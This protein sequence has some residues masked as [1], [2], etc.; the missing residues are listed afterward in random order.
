MQNTVRVATSQISWKVQRECVHFQ[1]ALSKH[2]VDF[3]GN[4]EQ[5]LKKSLSWRTDSILSRKSRLATVY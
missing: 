4:L 1:V 2:W 3:K 5:Y